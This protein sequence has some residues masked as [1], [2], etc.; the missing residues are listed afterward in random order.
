MIICLLYWTAST[1]SFAMVQSL[2]SLVAF[3]LKQT[4][5]E[6]TKYKEYQDASTART[7][8]LL[9]GELPKRSIQEM[10][11]FLADS[12]LIPS[13]SNLIASQICEYGPSYVRQEE[14]DVLEF[15][16]RDLGYK[17]HDVG[18]LAAALHY[19]GN[20]AGMEPLEFLGDG[21]L[22]ILMLRIWHILFRFHP[23]QGGVQPY[24]LSRFFLNRVGYHLNLQFYCADPCPPGLLS[25]MK[26]CKAKNRYEIL[27]GDCGFKR[28]YLVDRFEAVLGAMFLDCK[29]DFDIMEPILYDILAPF[30]IGVMSG[31]WVGEKP[32]VWA[33]YVD[34]LPGNTFATIESALRDARG[35]L[36]AYSIV[37][38]RSRLS[39]KI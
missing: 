8:L 2:H 9:L 1:C 24:A 32:V 20:Y 19:N 12:N 39:K 37:D 36:N 16:Q 35:K 31:R 25:F 34:W 28:K 13:R 14:R 26:N 27:D 23:D 15:L 3:H 10:W 38:L 22:N 4:P 11:D 30:L 5:A 17:F 21:I 29:L 18:L 6:M 7:K 33:C